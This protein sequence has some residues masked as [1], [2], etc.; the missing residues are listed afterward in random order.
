MPF[1][2]LLFEYVKSPS[3]RHLRDAHCIHKLAREIV[4][5]LDRGTS[6]WKKWGPER[7]EVA[8]AAVS[9]WIPVEDLLAFLDTLPGPSLTKTDVEQR[10]RAISEEP[11]TTYPKDDLKDGC[12]WR[13]KKQEG[14]LL[15]T[16]LWRRIL[17]AKFQKIASLIYQLTDAGPWVLSRLPDKYLIIP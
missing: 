6:T 15:R 2:S 12:P 14:D 11:Y 9:C 4:T 10:L 5:A 8:K 1:A 3:L 17:D 13:C 16:A 7:E